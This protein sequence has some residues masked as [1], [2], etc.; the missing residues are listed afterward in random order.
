MA[1]TKKSEKNVP[2]KKIPTKS[3]TK[4]TAKN[5]TKDSTKT[6]PNTS[7]KTTLSI[8]QK[9][10]VGK[11][12]AA[13][14]KKK[15]AEKMKKIKVSKK[16]SQIRYGH[17]ECKKK[18]WA[19]ATKIE[20]KNPM[21]CRLCGITGKVLKYTDH[22]KP[23][24]YG[25][26]IDHLIPVAKGGSDHLSNLK[27]VNYKVNRSQ[28]A[29]FVNKLHLVNKYH[30][31]LAEKRGIQPSYKNLEFKWT[32][33]LIGKHC[34]VRATPVATQSLAII[35]GYTSKWVEVQWSDTKWTQQIPVN[36]DLFEIMK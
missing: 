32:P 22:G 14:G 29:S 13:E 26:D 2:T 25:W 10:T 27:A 30:T 18:V 9:K 4:S 24:K 35:K 11:K 16:K 28:G 31:A 17:S 19:K 15:V 21:M 33:D 20:G 3:T 5:S 23:T 36:K 7:T 1:P 8:S 12:A 6:T 34:W